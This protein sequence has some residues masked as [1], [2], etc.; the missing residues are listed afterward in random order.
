MVRELL[1]VRVLWSVLRGGITRHE[2]EDDDGSQKEARNPS[3]DH[4]HRHD[5]EGAVPYEYSGI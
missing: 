1:H 3:D 5:A 2:G 4:W